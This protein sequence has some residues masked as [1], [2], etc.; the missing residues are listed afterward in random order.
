MT[1]SNAQDLKRLVLWVEPEA[2]D[3]LRLAAKQPHALGGELPAARK[4]PVAVIQ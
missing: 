2:V 1:K 3:D 4:P